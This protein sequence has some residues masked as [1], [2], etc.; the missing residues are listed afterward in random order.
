MAITA[1]AGTPDQPILGAATSHNRLKTTYSE[2]S[3]GAFQQPARN[4]FCVPSRK[5]LRTRIGGQDA[6]R[7]IKTLERI[8][9]V[10]IMILACLLTWRRLILDLCTALLPARAGLSQCIDQVPQCLWPLHQ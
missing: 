2:L 3:R 4:V 8:G 10:D 9:I 6:A 5:A 1:A 7:Q